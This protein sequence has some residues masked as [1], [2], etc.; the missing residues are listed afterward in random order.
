M[1]QLHLYYYSVLLNTILKYLQSSCWWGTEGNGYHLKRFTIWS[2]WDLPPPWCAI[3]CAE[4][5]SAGT[6]IAPCQV[7]SLYLTYECSVAYSIPDCI[8][9]GTTA[10]ISA[11]SISIPE[12]SLE[13][14][15]HL[16]TWTARLWHYCH[17]HHHASTLAFGKKWLVL[18]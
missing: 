17:L 7:S 18:S 12:L 14:V 8:A 11:N 4:R 15:V 3:T 6:K 10:I 16:G 1:R 13:S 2:S 5:G 9:Y